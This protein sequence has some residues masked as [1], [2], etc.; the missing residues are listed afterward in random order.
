MTLRRLN[1][2]HDQEW[3]CLDN[4]RLAEVRHKVEHL[5]HG[6]A[7][8]GLLLQVGANE[9][10]IYLAP[11]NGARTHMATQAAI[12]ADSVWL[13]APSPSNSAYQPPPVRKKLGMTA[14]SLSCKLGP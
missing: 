1:A 11:M 12:R 4:K 5:L 14:L 13:A 7:V 2:K 10:D 8:N 3:G 6:K 9:P